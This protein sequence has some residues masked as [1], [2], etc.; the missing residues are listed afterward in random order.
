MRN[1]CW[2]NTIFHN[3]LFMFI[4]IQKEKNVQ[5]CYFNLTAKYKKYSS[6]YSIF[7]PKIYKQ[8]ESFHG[9]LWTNKNKNKNVTSTD[10]I[11]VSLQIL[12]YGCMRIWLTNNFNTVAYECKYML[13]FLSDTVN[14]ISL[15]GLYQKLM[16][17]KLKCV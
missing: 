16:I 17:T 13:P 9:S 5:G 7:A 14:I 6:A 4:R 8:Y 3:H 1:G 15:D 2:L 10:P 11:F 12:I